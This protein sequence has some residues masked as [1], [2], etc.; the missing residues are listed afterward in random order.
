M[1]LRSLFSPKA[2]VVAALPLAG[3]GDPQQTANAIAILN[4]AARIAQTVNSGSLPNG[5]PIRTQTTQN[6]TCPS[7]WLKTRSAN[8]SGI[9][10]S[11]GRDVG[12]YWCNKPSAF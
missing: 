8:A 11:R 6:G 12:T 1:N 10:D 3:C 5:R 2:L 9:Y 4:E 7:G